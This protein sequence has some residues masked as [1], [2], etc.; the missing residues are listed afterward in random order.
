MIKDRYKVR[1]GVTGDAVG[2]EAW[3]HVTSDEGAVRAALR[4]VRPYGRDGWWI[5]TGREGRPVARGGR[6]GFLCV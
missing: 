6:F 5:V 1:V 4:A 2:C 3:H